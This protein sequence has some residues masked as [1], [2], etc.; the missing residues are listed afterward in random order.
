M[1]VI[2]EKQEVLDGIVFCYEDRPETFFY[3]IYDKK[4][5]KYRSKKVEGATTLTEAS[6]KALAAHDYLRGCSFSGASNGGNAERLPFT[7]ASSSKS[8]TPYARLIDTY[9]D[10]YVK[11]QQELC[12]NGFITEGTYNNKKVAIDKHLREYLKTKAILRTSELKVNTFDDYLIF[13][14]QCSKLTRQRELQ[15]I[16][17]WVRW[18]LKEEVVHPKLSQIEVPTERIGEEDLTANPAINPRDWDL[19]TKTIRDWKDE[20]VA[21]SRKGVH[22]YRTLFHT[23]CLVMKNTGCRP[24]ELRMLQWKD[25]EVLPLTDEEE[26]LRREG[27]MNSKLTDKVATAYI[28]I[29]KSKTRS[30][31]EVPARVGRELR[32]WRDYTKEYLKEANVRSCLTLDS[33]VF[34]N[35]NNEWRPYARNLF[36]N[37]W[38]NN[39]ILPLAGQLR[40]HK[41]SDKNYTLYSMRSTY[42]EDNL[43]QEGGCDVFLLATVCGH[44]VKILQKHYERINVRLRAGELT[45]IPYGKRDNREESVT[46]LL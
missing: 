44:D 7:I 20:A 12:L 8:T 28:F 19:I 45:K 34:G 3:R 27:K 21:H 6:R 15:T 22:F 26:E 2:K 4:T 23:F 1:P 24:S 40:G 36:S 10:L 35:P 46:S 38:H 33:F 31:R 42:I 13:R 16:Q 11:K 39:V 41:M 14:S 43:L 18:L 25:I 5:Q 32:R 17:Q 29:K 9:I 37:T 30:Q